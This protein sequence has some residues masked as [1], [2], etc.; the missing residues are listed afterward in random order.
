MPITNHVR[1]ATGLAALLV[2]L[3]GGFGVSATAQAQSSGPSEE[4]TPPRLSFVDGQVS[5]WRPGAEEW[6]TAQVNTPLAPGVALFA[7]SA[8]KFEIQVGWLAYA[9]AWERAQ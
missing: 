3:V 8:G 1:T 7:D 9:R 4:R 2:A 5:F 6:T